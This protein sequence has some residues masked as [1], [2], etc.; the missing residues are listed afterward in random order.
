[1]LIRSA[2]PF[3]YK[4]FEIF[5]Q[6]YNKRKHYIV[7]HYGVLKFYFV[8]PLSIRG[9]ILQPYKPRENI[10]FEVIMTVKNVLM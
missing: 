9:H 4:V 6:H 3:N 7:P 5:I 2:C 1:L 10:K 8:L